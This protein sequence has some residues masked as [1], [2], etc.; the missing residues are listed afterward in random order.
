MSALGDTYIALSIA[1]VILSL[2]AYI[3]AR[4]LKDRYDIADIAW[5]PSFIVTAWISLILARQPLGWQQILPVVLVTLWGLRLSWH[6]LRRFQRSSGDPRYLAMVAGWKQHKQ[7]QTYFRIFFSQELLMLLI[8]TPVI[9]AVTHASTVLVAVVLGTLVWLVG[10]VFESVADRQL[11]LFLANPAHKGALLTSGLWAHSRHPNYFGE[12]TQWWG[13]AIIALGSPFGYVGMLG[14]ALITL[15]I[16]KVSGI[17][18]VEARYKGRKDWEEYA[19]R[20]RALLPL[21][22]R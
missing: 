16:T 22:K 1:V 14:A 17:P 9:L 15:L 2:I 13:L 18:L 12:V 11:A 20:V 5:G 21:P 8:S 4:A 19:G 7:L 6:I 10:F 3:V